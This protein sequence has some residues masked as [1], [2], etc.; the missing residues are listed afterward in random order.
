MSAEGSSAATENR[1][2]D[3]SPTT[4]SCKPSVQPGM[5]AVSGNVM[6]APCTTELSTMWP[7]G[8]QP[9]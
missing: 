4:M 1:A 5:T 9:V 7:S 2:S 3:F 6:G 8:V